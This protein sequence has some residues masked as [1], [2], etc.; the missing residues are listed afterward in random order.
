MPFREECYSNEPS[1][2]YMVDGHH[3]FSIKKVECHYLSRN[4][5]KVLNKRKT[6][7]K[8]RIEKSGLFIKF[9]FHNDVSFWHMAVIRKGIVSPLC[10]AAA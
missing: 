8:D 7:L 10:H 2:L 9:V 6:A 4:A 5:R 1:I 3:S